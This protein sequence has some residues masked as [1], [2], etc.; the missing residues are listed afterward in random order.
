[1]TIITFIL[2]EFNMGKRVSGRGR[3]WRNES[4]RH[5]LAGMGIKT[6]NKSMKSSGKKHEFADDL[7]FSTAT[8]KCGGRPAQSK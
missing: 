2:G 3:G 8:L 5:R 7:P 1:M 4:H 6:G